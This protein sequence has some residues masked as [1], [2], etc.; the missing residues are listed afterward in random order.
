MQGLTAI[1]KSYR[2]EN[3]TQDF[4]SN[5]WLKETFVSGKYE[6]VEGLCKIVDVKEV[7][8]NDWS[9]TPGRYVGYSITLDEDFDYTKR[10]G[11]IHGELK[12]LNDEAVGLM[13][14]ILRGPV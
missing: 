8:E 6:D 14:K 1:I 4:A 13:E 10:L 12:G 11:E 3:V 9:L 7:E 5:S 2:G